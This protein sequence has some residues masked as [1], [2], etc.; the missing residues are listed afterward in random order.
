MANISNALDR[1]V[2]S[3]TEDREKRGNILHFARATNEGL[4]LEGPVPVTIPGKITS[5]APYNVGDRVAVLFDNSRPVVI[6]SDQAASDPNTIIIGG[7]THQRSGS[8]TTGNVTLIASGVFFQVD[9]Q[10]YANTLPVA[11]AG[12]GRVYTITNTTVNVGIVWAAIAT[13][14]GSLIAV[15]R[16]G[17]TTVLTVAW[18]L[19]KL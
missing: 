8:F 7:K 17:G 11:P 5:L 10:S 14:T 19:I 16:V 3:A 18:Q 1:L 15:S 6:G 12:W 4:V 2:A 13:S 9:I